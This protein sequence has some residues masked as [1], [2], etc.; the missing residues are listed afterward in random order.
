MV[1]TP[2][3]RTSHSYRLVLWHML[4]RPDMDTRKEQIHN[5]TVKSH[6]HQKVENFRGIK[7]S[8]W[9]F[10][11][12]RI[13]LAF[14]AV[15]RRWRDSWKP[16]VFLQKNEQRWHLWVLLGQWGQDWLKEARRVL[17]FSQNFPC[18]PWSWAFIHTCPLFHLENIFSFFNT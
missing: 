16:S 9:C 12:K 7:S 1:F 8:V 3:V 13:V 17:V 4:M 5:E 10:W 11:G 2:A 15:F 18:L 6:F 14:R